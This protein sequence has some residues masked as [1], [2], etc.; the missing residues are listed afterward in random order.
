VG[1]GRTIEQIATWTQLA[2]TD[3]QRITAT[4]FGDGTASSVVLNRGQ[5]R[6]VSLLPA[7]TEMLFALGL[8][9][10]VV[11]VS[12][13]CDVPSTAQPRPAVSKPALA[14]KHLSQ[15]E[16]DEAVSQR[17]ASG[18]SLYEIDE[19]LLQDLRPDLIL[20]QDLC[21]VCAPSG[22]ELSAALASLNPRPRVLSMT[23]HT[24]ADIFGNMRELGAMT[25]RMVEAEQLMADWR[26]RLARIKAAA[27]SDA[28]R[29]RVFF[30]EWAD[31][32]YC[33]GHWVPEMIELVGGMDRLGRVGCDSVRLA[34]EQIQRWDPELL[35]L[36]PCGCNL[37]QSLAQLSLLSALPGWSN[38]EAVRR[39]Q[40]FCVN[41]NAYF[42]RPGPRVVDGTELLAHLI[43][44]DL[45]EWNGP[46]DAYR[47]CA[48]NELE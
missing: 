1:C 23:P 32:I 44:P 36:G 39:G 47:R 30:M 33:S 42:A 3:R 37:E 43:R 25:S 38:L 4:L 45:F 24:L 46:A 16:I 28:P 13:E 2:E 27:P 40:V 6:I 21:Q 8:G 12:H 35:I 31:P 18:K 11:G 20:T 19:Q 41:A 7:A 9:N 22:S 15:R 34:W 14:L 48:A 26:R 10:A 29:P 17:L 5:L